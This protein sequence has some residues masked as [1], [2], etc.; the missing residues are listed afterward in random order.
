M[1]RLAR[2]FRLVRANHDRHAGREGLLCRGRGLGYAG[3]VDGRYALTVFS[4]GEASVS[5]MMELPKVPGKW[6]RGRCGSDMSA[7]TT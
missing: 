2:S 5:G 7:S 3:R 6:A 1:V 4:G